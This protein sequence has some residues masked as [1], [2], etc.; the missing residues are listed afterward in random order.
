[1]P[2]GFPNNPAVNDTAL[3]NG[4]QYKWDGVA[5]RKTAASTASA[6]LTSYATIA[7][8]D[9]EDRNKISEA[10][11]A[12][13][14]QGNA[15][16]GLISTLNMIYYDWGDGSTTI[17]TGTDEVHTYADY[18][19]YLIK[20]MW[21]E[22]I[23]KVGQ[24]KLAFWH[25]VDDTGVQQ[26][27]SMTDTSSNPT[28]YVEN[29]M[30]LQVFNTFSAVGTPE[31][32]LHDDSIPHYDDHISGAYP[33][34]AE[35]MIVDSIDTA[36]STNATNI[37]TNTTDIATITAAM[38]TDT[39]R[40]AAVTAL[41]TAYDAAD[42]TLEGLLTTAIAGKLST[43]GGTLTGS[44]Y[45]A[46]GVV[47]K[48]GAGNDLEIYH[49]G[50][51]SYINETGDGDLLI[52]S[53]GANVKIISDGDEDIARFTKDGGAQLYYNNSKKIETSS[54][55]IDV[56][57]S[58]KFTNWTL[59][60]SGGVLYFATGGTNKMKLDASGNLTVTGDITAFGSV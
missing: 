10:I 1:M 37:A 32:N 49:N 50:S 41:T 11:M 14:G 8:S 27:S 21:G 60:E 31:I 57:G 17:Q 6:D 2:Q 48:F 23:K 45:F 53:Q 29:G 13:A 16:L 58:L 24:V 51:N 46:D 54:T 39:E 26:I 52:K 42:T 22:P 38:S 59:T 40:L 33:F 28:I 30:E 47:A 56:F 5:W 25:L 20:V 43:S 34:Y 19:W 35:K 55:G 9:E 44:V 3:L 18:G 12:Q 15:P 7:Y 36:V 4:S